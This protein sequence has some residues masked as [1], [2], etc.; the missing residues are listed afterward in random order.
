MTIGQRKCSWE[1]CCGNL[2]GELNLFENGP[3]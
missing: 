2:H 3:F 1:D